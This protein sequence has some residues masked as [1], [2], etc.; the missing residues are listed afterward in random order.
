[1]KYN[2]FLIGLFML[3]SIAATSQPDVYYASRTKKDSH[4][5]GSKNS[6]KQSLHELERSFGVSIAYKDEWVEGQKAPRDISSFKSVE[7]ALNELFKGTSLFYEKAG[8]RFYVIYQRPGN[9]KQHSESRAAVKLLPPLYAS[10]SNIPEITARKVET[11]EVAN[12]FI[13][14]GTVRDEN[15]TT[16]PVVN[17]I[18]KGTTTGTSTDINGAYSLDAITSDAILVFSFVGYATPEVAVGGRTVIDVS[19]TP[20]I[21]ALDELVV[22]ALGIER[23]SRGLGYSTTKVNADELVVNRTPNVM[24]ALQGKIAGV[25]ISSLGTGPGGTSKIR[26]RGQSSISGQNNPLIVING[27]P[28]DNTNFGT[29]PNNQ[30]SDNSIGVRGGGITADGGDGLQSI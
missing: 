9:P 11:Y 4:H 13:V 7:D 16:F 8:E 6:L 10:A 2:Y 26:I 5:E 22:T 27:V 18:I 1:M 3:A 19:M 21:K 24:N 23:S 30:A 15:N 17:I 29:N 20:D 25:N 14:T 12:E 28:I